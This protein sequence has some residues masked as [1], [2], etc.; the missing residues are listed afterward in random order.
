MRFSL[1]APDGTFLEHHRRSIVGSGSPLRSLFNDGSY[2]DWAPVFPDGRFGARIFFSA[3]TYAPG[4]ERVD[5][6]PPI[7][8]T[9]DMVPSGKM[10]LMDYG[11]FVVASADA[12]RNIW[13]ADSRKYRIFR[14]SLK[15]DTTL[16]LTLPVKA[17]PVGE[18][19]R[20]YVRQRWAHRPDIGAEQLAGLPRTKPVIYGIMPDNAG[21]LYVFAD[22][23]GEA[24]GTVV[25]VFRESGQYLGRLALPAPVVLMP[26]RPPV[27]H[28]TSEYLYF[29]VT[30]DMD[31]PYVSRL[32]IVKEH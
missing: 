32:K 15:G 31:V 2:L 1:F 6:F 19:E 25:D 22:V 5:T 14:R 18:A 30:D 13:F 4:F 8:F 26:G 28:I 27:A 20:E 17:L 24:S 16:A 11:G 23:A 12:H 21:H 29:V 3:I 10:Q 7:E 9:Q